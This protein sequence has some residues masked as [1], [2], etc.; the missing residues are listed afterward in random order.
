V[1]RTVTE[2][3]R[4]TGQ[5]IISNV[6]NKNAEPFN[7]LVATGSGTAVLYRVMA[8]SEGSQISHFDIS[9][10][11]YRAYFNIEF[12]SVFDSVILNVRELAT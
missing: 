10:L 11:L 1:H 8:S 5:S 3:E 12:R 6:H 9:T 4:E 2:R 7:E